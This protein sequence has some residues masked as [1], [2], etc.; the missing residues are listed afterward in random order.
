MMTQ[1]SYRR[2]WSMCST[3]L[4]ASPSLSLSLFIWLMLRSSSYH[5]CGQIFSNSIKT[6]VIDANNDAQMLLIRSRGWCRHCMP[7]SEMVAMSQGGNGKRWSHC[8]AVD[9]W[10]RTL[11]CVQT[12]E[13]DELDLSQQCLDV[14]LTECAHCVRLLSCCCSI[15]FFMPF[16]E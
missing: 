15:F 4:H 3:P 9:C 16:I 13:A 6:K 8:N 11:M 2:L 5:R 10:W 12:F 1:S 7:L 14:R